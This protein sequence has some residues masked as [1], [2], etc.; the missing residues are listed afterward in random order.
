M[1]ALCVFVI[2]AGMLHHPS[3]AQKQAAKLNL[4]AFLNNLKKC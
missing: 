1:N 4:G 2:C 3:F